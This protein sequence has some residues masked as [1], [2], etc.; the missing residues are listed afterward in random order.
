VDV[1]TNS[2]RS[3]TRP[4]R[5]TSSLSSER[6]WTAALAVCLTVDHSTV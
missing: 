3:G 1:A 2:G 5:G 4:G 6:R